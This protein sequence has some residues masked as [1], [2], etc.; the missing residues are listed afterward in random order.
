MIDTAPDVGEHEGS[1]PSYRYRPKT[2]R[3]EM[4]QSAESYLVRR[5]RYFRSVGPSR[6]KNRL[7]SSAC[8]PLGSSVAGW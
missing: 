6:Q 5:T 7:Q 1:I 2:D 8:G 4:L 3:S